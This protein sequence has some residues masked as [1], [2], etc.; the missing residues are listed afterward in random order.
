MYYFRGKCAKQENERKMSGRDEE[1]KNKKEE[2][3]GQRERRK[4]HGGDLAEQREE[5]E[6]GGAFAC[7]PGGSP[8]HPAKALLNVGRW[9]HPVNLEQKETPV[10]QSTAYSCTV[11]AHYE[12][13]ADGSIY[14]LTATKSTSSS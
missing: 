14:L 9:L 1:N 2:R 10:K 6:A 3:K 13:R 8:Q 11:P 5:G 7:K 12:P 4:T